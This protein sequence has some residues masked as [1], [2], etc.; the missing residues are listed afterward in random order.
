M[1]HT[2]TQIASIIRL[3]SAIITWSVISSRTRKTPTV[4]GVKTSQRN[5]HP[6]EEPHGLSTEM[7][8]KRDEIII[9]IIIRR[10]STEIRAPAKQQ[11][12]RKIH[13]RV[14]ITVF[15]EV[16]EGIIQMTCMSPQHHGYFRWG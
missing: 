9:I 8:Y 10:N 16:Y 1:F 3:V 13:E 2:N 12:A 4:A 6:R 7:E 15:L 5:R 11:Q 14:E